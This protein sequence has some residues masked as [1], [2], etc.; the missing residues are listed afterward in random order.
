MKQNIN[1]KGFAAIVAV[2]SVLTLGLIFSSAFLFT[3][4]SGAKT[5]RNEADST[6]SYYASEA[7]IEDAIYRIKNGKSIGSQTVLTVGSAIATTTIATV[8]Q[9]K[10]ITAEGTLA[11]AMRKVQTELELSAEEADFYYGVQIGAG[12]LEMKQNSVINGSIY[13]DGSLGCPSS[14]TGAKINGDAWVAG[15]VGGVDQSST[16][17]SA[18]LFVGTTAGSVS[19]SVDTAGDV[20]AYD[21]LALGT[22]GFARISYYDGSNRDLKF[23]RCTNADC[24]TKNI[25]SVDT[26]GDMGWR[27]T[28]LAMGADGFAR[29]SYY[30]NTNGDLKFIQCTNADCSAKN[31]TSIETTND[32]GQFSSLAL[33]ADGFA[34]I[35][36]YSIS[37]GDLKFVQCTNADCSTKNITSV[38]TGG[39]V[40]KY[41]AL[42]LGAD[43]FARISYIDETNDDLKFVQCTNAACSTKNIA[44]VDTGGSLNQNTA[45]VLDAGDL[46]HISYYDNTNGDLK[47]GQCTNAACSTKN[48]TSVDTSDDVGK[49]SAIKLGADTFP[50][51]SYYDGGGGSVELARCTNAGC[52][53]KTISTVDTTNDTGHYTSLALGADGFARIS[54]YNNTNGDLLFVRCADDACTPGGVQADAAQSF[55][56]SADSPITKVSLYLK[57]VGSP[58]DATMRIIDDVSGA[59]GSAGDVVTTGTMNASSVGTTYAWIDVGFSTNPTLNNTQTYWIVLDGGNDASNYC[60]CGY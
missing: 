38:D 31:I 17:Q 11:Q 48:I 42:A 40:G 4:M 34:R 35:S 28:S 10:T 44:S 23:V 43:G 22:D 18:A 16:V 21:S 50:R 20:G 8:G 58:P 13:S 56:P 1:E 12:G 24:S 37:A 47:F 6:Q 51:I 53:A 36:Y 27:Y 39:D 33:G 2:I 15:G 3:T 9:T 14:C 30:N 26:T 25:T 55:Q 19:S 29:I 7:G 32:V 59:P 5:L 57:K 46:A 54:Y 49:Y 60:V 52:T 45:L 41:T